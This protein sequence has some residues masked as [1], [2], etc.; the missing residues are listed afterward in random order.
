ME[1]F[2]KLTLMEA[3]D[4]LRREF[5]QQNGR[6]LTEEEAVELTETIRKDIR[7]NGEKYTFESIRSRR[8]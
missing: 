4:E 8:H 6:L 1:E 2:K 7:E 3:I 5:E